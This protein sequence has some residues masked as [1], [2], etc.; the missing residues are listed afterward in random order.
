MANSASSWMPPLPARR[1]DRA[2][3]TPSAVVRRERFA[4]KHPEI[5]IST[6]REDGQLL[7]EAPDPDGAVKEY[8]DANAMMNDLETWYP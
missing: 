1:D 7:F 8:K 5:P 6:R 2:H 3:H 4:R